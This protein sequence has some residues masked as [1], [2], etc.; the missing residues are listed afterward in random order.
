MYPRAEDFYDPV[1]VVFKSIVG[2]S[3]Q[4]EQTFCKSFDR[5]VYEISSDLRLIH[6]GHGR[7]IPN[8]LSL[9]NPT[10]KHRNLSPW[11]GKIINSLVGAKGERRINFFTLERKIYSMKE[12]WTN[13]KRIRRFSFSSCPPFFF[14]FPRLNTGPRHFERRDFRLFISTLWSALAKLSKESKV[15]RKARFVILRFESKPSRIQKFQSRGKCNR[16]M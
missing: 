12:G 15:K 2:S 9:E 11:E 10:R 13:S 5:F 7:K 16:L 1:R 14:L 3:G 4:E 8:K 6:Q